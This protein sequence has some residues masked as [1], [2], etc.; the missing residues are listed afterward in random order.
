MTLLHTWKS[1]VESYSTKKLTIETD[2]LPA[3]SG[4]AKRFQN[5]LGG[6]YLAGLW[7]QH[8]VSGLAWV[9]YYPGKR[10]E[11]YIA[12]SWSW[13]SLSD[14]K[15]G[16]SG[17]MG[18]EYTTLIEIHECVCTSTGLDE[19][20]AVSDGYLRLSGYLT[21]G[22]LEQSK[23]GEQPFFLSAGV[24]NNSVRMDSPITELTE[25]LPITSFTLCL[26][27]HRLLILRKVEPSLDRFVRIGSAIDRTNRSKE[28]GE[29]KEITI[30]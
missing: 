1:T 14:C 22:T 15:I 10:P 26:L 27:V 6:R 28:R 12:P 30:V 20:G 17:C 11:K 7:E 13:A 23:P 29:W 5:V 18:F 9:T 24:R 16:L 19:T 2:R 21:E 25:G 4:I 8:L 3:L